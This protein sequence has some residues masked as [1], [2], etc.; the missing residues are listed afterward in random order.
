MKRTLPV[1]LTA[2]IVSASAQVQAFDTAAGKDLVNDNCTSCHGN[3][4]YTRQNRLV[5]SRAGLTKQV[6]RC[7]LALGLT[8]FD[9]DVNNAA[10][11]LN[12]QF[13]RFSK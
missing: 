8:W 12:Q 7:E 5:T 3:E 1:L 6:K 4:F 13:Y 11:Y 10:E 2:L 9:E